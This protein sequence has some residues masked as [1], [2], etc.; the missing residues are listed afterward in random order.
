M[1]WAAHCPGC[2]TDWENVRSCSGRSIIVRKLLH[3]TCQHPSLPPLQPKPANATSSS[4]LSSSSWSSSS[5]SSIS[6]PTSSSSSSSSPSPLPSSSSSSSSSSPPPSSSSSSSSPS[7]HRRRRRHR[8]DNC[9]QPLKTTWRMAKPTDHQHNRPDTTNT[10]PPRYDQD[11]VNTLNQHGSRWDT[12]KTPPRPATPP[13]HH[14]DT[15]KTPPRHH[16]DMTETARTPPRHRDTT[17]TPPKP[18]KHQ[19]DTT[20]TPETPHHR[21]PHR[22]T[23]QAGSRK[24]DGAHPP[25]DFRVNNPKL[26]LLGN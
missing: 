16:Q 14:P 22:D 7:C 25:L 24:P 1:R 5:S 3:N 8:H 20:E 17:E 6:I 13:R 10:T 11:T 12:T 15:T 19:W 9:M 23:A 4:S 26:S 2:F 18:P 21:R